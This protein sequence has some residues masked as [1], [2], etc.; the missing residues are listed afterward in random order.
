MTSKNRVA[1]IAGCGGINGGACVSYF[2]NPE[3]SKD[4]NWEI[5]GLANSQPKHMPWYGKIKVECINLLDDNE[6]KDKIT[7]HPDIARATHLIFAAYKEEKTEEEMIK[8]NLTMLRNCLTNISSVSKNLEKVVLYTGTKY[9]GIH[10]GPYKTP[11]SEEDPRLKTPNFYYA[12]EDFLAD[13]QRGK[14]WT[15]NVVRPNEVIGYS[16]GF[17]NLGVTL[18]IYASICKET[19][20]KFKFPGTV[21][22]WEVLSDASDSKLIAKMIHWFSMTDNPDVPNQAFNI[23]NGDLYR[24]KLLWPQIAQYFGVEYEGPKQ[25]EHFKLQEGMK[26]KGDAWK[27]IVEKYHLTQSDDLSKVTTF[28]FADLWMGKEYDALEDMNKAR[29]AGWTGWKNTAKSYFC[30]F[31]EL[32]E[33]GVIPTFE[34]R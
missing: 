12:Q 13:F 6:A 1:V 28:G 20:M 5:I 30:L 2:L 27:K 11:A 14:Q 24:W 7:H 21:R 18:A 22:S 3:L 34:R 10:L 33:H 26:D 17:M 15:Y 29:E 16:K 19:G 9:Y 8:T 32:K 23:V 4:T 25:G 31:D